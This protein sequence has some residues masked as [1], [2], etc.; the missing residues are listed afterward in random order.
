MLLNH[1]GPLDKTIYDEEMR[2][3]Y[4]NQMNNMG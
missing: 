3:L 2:T 4:F 1:I